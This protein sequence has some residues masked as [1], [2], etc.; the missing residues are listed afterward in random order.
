MPKE[1]PLSEQ[2]DEYIAWALRGMRLPSGY[3]SDLLK[4]AAQRIFPRPPRKKPGR[5]PGFTFPKQDSPKK[6]QE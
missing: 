5:K 3:N 6:E 1:R 2:S 4:E